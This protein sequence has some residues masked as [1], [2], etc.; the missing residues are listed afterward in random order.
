M[1]R[2]GADAAARF[3]DQLVEQHPLL[4]ARAADQAHDVVAH[5]QEQQPLADRVGADVQ[6]DHADLSGHEGTRGIYAHQ[7]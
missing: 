1:R 3:A 2:I 7:G 6:T 5:F 4:R